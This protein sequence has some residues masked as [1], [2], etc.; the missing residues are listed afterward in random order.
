MKLVGHAHS[1]I[2]RVIDS[3]GKGQTLVAT[4]LSR[5]GRSDPP[6]KLKRLAKMEHDHSLG[7]LHNLCSDR[8]QDIKTIPDV[9]GRLVT[10]FVFVF[11]FAFF[12]LHVRGSCREGILS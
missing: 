3:L 1:A 4:V 2:W 9:L 6:A 8:N 12:V 7:K 5:D 10:L 11:M